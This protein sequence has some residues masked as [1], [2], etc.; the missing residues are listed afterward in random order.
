MAAGAGCGW[1]TR[2]AEALTRPLTRAVVVNASDPATDV[3]RNGAPVAG[4]RTLSG[5]LTHEFTHGIL[6]RRYGIVAMAMQPQWKVEGYGDHVAQEYSLS[7]EEVARLEAD[8][9]NHPALPY[10]HGRLQVTQRLA[11]NGGSV[12]ALFATTDRD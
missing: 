3:V 11:A 7:A 9:T 2:R 8:G 12:D 5:V 1:P 6:R 10:Y 4:E